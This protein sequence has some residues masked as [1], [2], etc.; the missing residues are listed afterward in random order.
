MP[1][2]PQGGHSR[3]PIPLRHREN[4]VLEKLFNNPADRGYWYLLSEQS[5]TALITSFLPPGL[6]MCA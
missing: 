6:Y 3:G 1:Y 5:F 2:G 4:N